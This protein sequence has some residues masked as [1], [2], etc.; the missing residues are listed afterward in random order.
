MSKENRFLQLFF[1]AVMILY[2]IISIIGGISWYSRFDALENIGNLYA[3][4]FI[5]PIAS[6][7]MVYFFIIITAIIVSL[8]LL[9]KDDFKS[10]KGYTIIAMTIISPF[11]FYV[12]FA[13]WISIR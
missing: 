12:H 8:R 5:Y 3:D 7:I 9:T 6:S 10:A 2:S 4:I 13:S 11:A 1:L